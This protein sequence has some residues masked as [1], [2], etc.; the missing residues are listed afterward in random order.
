MARIN[1]RGMNVKAAAVPMVIENLWLFSA[2]FFT[3]TLALLFSNSRQACDYLPFICNP[4]FRVILSVALPFLWF[5]AL[6]LFGR[7]IL[8]RNLSA[9][10]VLFLMLEQTAAWLFFGISLWL[11]FP[12]GSGSDFLLSA[13]SA[14]C[15]SWLAG[16]AVFFAPGGI[17][18]REAALAFLLSAFFPAETVA[19]FAAIHR[20]LWVLIELLL[21]A[22][23]ALVFGIP[24]GK[25]SSPPADQ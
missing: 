9:R 7:L 2:A 1:P 17:G 3:G 5:L 23:A 16:Y 15:V 22:G 8:K 13:V 21:G 24:L 4:L 14:F 12:A 11:V 25:P 10:T 6:M 19:I 20:L 18:V